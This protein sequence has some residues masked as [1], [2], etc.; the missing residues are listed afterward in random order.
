MMSSRNF[1]MRARA[2]IAVV[3]AAAMLAGC[4][5]KGATSQVAVKVNSGEITINQLSSALSQIPNVA[6][7]QVKQVKRIMLDKLVDQQLFVQQAITDKLDRTPKVVEE[8]D[9]ARRAILARAYVEKVVSGTT[10]ATTEDIGKYYDSHPELFAQRKVY[11]VQ[12]YE[13]V[14]QPG[15]AA[16]LKAEVS[17]GSSLD[18]IGVFLKAKGAQFSPRAGVITPEQAPLELLPKLKA[19][20][21]GQT[22]IIEGPNSI[23]VMHVVA[24]R[25]E[26]VDLKTAQ[27]SIKKFLE[28]G[29]AK[30]AVG[31][32]LKR[33]KGEAKIEYVG[34][35][36]KG[37]PVEPEPKPVSE[38][39][40]STDVE[41]GVA[42][43]LK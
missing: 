3:S 12:E 21:D 33:L 11:N 2:G 6:P 38:K 37:A 35:F 16:S 42:G 32:E 34:E 39:A 8:I 19:I 23:S 5:E 29:R 25:P 15:L 4:G 27:D 14:P 1:T 40:G 20:Q 9:S 43:L 7:E 36:A 41:K 28:N 18:Q 26:P 10:P 13:V 24:S 17:K 31:A 22:D 30:D